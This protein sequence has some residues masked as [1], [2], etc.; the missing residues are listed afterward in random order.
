MAT[1]RKKDS[2][3]LLLQLVSQ[4][5]SA[6]RLYPHRRYE[7][8]TPTALQLLAALVQ[9]SPASITELAD[10]LVLDRATISPVLEQ[11]TAEGYVALKHD[12][13]DGR[14][15]LFAIRSHGRRLIDCYAREVS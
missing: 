10:R 3:A 11:L 5:A 14:R 4:P 8:L 9:D 13:D 12:Q 1:G 6:R 15:R 2:D 7:G